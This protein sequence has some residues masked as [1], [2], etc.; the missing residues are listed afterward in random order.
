MTVIFENARSNIQAFLDFS[1]GTLFGPED[2]ERIVSTSKL[3]AI[4]DMLDESNLQYTEDIEAWLTTQEQF[5]TIAA[6]KHDTCS[7]AYASSWAANL[8]EG[9]RENFV[10]EYGDEEGDDRLSDDDIA[11]LNRRAAELVGWYV[12]RARVWR[13]EQLR[14]FTFD[15]ADVLQMVRE[16]RP[17]WLKKKSERDV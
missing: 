6:Y 3:G 9:L 12:S 13:C 4:E 17:G 11:E 16:L 5:W 1:E 7:E 8:A 14:T 10:D 2:T 15:S